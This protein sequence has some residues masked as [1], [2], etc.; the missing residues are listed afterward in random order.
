MGKEGADRGEF[1]VGETVSLAVV[2]QD[3]ESLRNSAQVSVF[4]EISGGKDFL[5]LGGSSSSAVAVNSRA[6]CSWFGFKVEILY[7]LLFCTPI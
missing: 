4:D 5:S 1:T 6:F 2:D 7:S 3:R